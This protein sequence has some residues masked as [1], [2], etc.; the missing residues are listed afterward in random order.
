LMFWE[1]GTVNLPPEARSPLR[2][3]LPALQSFI[4]LAVCVFTAWYLVSAARDRERARLDL[5]VCVGGGV[6]QGTQDQTIGI[7]IGCPSRRA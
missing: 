4:T 1:Y 7:A 5:C 3:T 6:F 2:L